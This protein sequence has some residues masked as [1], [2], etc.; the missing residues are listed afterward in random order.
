M[1]VSENQPSL[2]SFN[3]DGIERLVIDVFENAF[4]PMYWSS[5]SF[6]ISISIR[7]LQQKKA[8]QLF[9]KQNSIFIDE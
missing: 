7:L 3:F 6:G 9:L 5:E 2:S 1:D 4:S 8:F